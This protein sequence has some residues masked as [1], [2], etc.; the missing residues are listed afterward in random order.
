[1]DWISR[2][3]KIELAKTED[4]EIIHKFILGILTKVKINYNRSLKSIRKHLSNNF[5]EFFLELIC[6]LLLH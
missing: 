3:M 4:L 1:M 2:I 5:E 6:V